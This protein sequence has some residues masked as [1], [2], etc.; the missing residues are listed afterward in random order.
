MKSTIWYCNTKQQAAEGAGCYSLA[1][2]QP[3][4]DHSSCPTQSFPAAPPHTV[5][6]ELLGH[7]WSPRFSAGAAAR[8]LSLLGFL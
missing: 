3:R 7:S 8:C 1:A 2:S 6:C 4:G 5:G